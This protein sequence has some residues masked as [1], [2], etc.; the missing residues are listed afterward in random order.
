MKKIIYLF[1]FSSVC[2]TI[3]ATNISLELTFPPS[4]LL[5][6][7]G[8]SA[9]EMKSISK[10]NCPQVDGYYAAST[11][12]TPNI[13]FYLQRG[14]PFYF[15]N[16]G[17][18]QQRK[19]PSQIG[20]LSDVVRAIRA[21]SSNTPLPSNV[22]HQSFHK[23]RETYS[24]ESLI[25]ILHRNNPG[26][27]VACYNNNDQ[28]T[29]CPAGPGVSFNRGGPLASGATPQ[30]PIKVS[31]GTRDH[32][33]EWSFDIT[34]LTAAWKNDFSVLSALRNATLLPA[35]TSSSLTLNASLFK[36]TNTTTPA[37]YYFA[38]TGTDIYL[39]IHMISPGNSLTITDPNLVNYGPAKSEDG[40]FYLPYKASASAKQPTWLP[41]TQSYYPDDI[42]QKIGKSS[43]F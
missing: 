25:W 13:T 18:A 16:Y 41:W 17:F 7:A 8:A 36:P 31:R 43:S 24:G 6:I 11:S 19:F 14:W 35:S 37:S 32:S 2:T 21:T 12:D 33:T 27:S 39:P 40:D 23:S 4:A 30:N 15:M 20:Y 22:M 9:T 5:A 3:T 1:L 28:P 38:E 10:K 42:P 29:I 34:M 26:S